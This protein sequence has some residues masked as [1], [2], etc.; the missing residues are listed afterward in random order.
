MTSLVVGGVEFL[1][2]GE[3]LF[4]G[5]TIVRGAYFYS[6]KPPYQ[7]AVPMPQIEQEPAA[8][9]V[10]ASGDKF[11]VRYEFLPD[12]I[13]LQAANATD[14]AEP[15]FFVLDSALVTNV[16]NAKDERLTV[17]LAGQ[18]DP[19]WTTT[20]WKTDRAALKISRTDGGAVDLWTVGQARSQVWHGDVADKTAEFHLE[21]SSSRRRRSRP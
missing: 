3:P 17:P 4:N 12:G 10:K 7:G 21:P 6:E 19:K 16:V 14:F 13:R 9:V 20:T 8:N 5:K 11:S 18:P 15:F 2:P 1:R